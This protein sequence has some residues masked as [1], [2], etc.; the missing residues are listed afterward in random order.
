MNLKRLLSS[1]LGAMMLVPTAFAMDP[2]ER[3]ADSSSLT[4]EQQDEEVCKRWSKVLD[5]IE[6]NK[7]NLGKIS[8]IL[9]DLDKERKGMLDRGF[10]YEIT[11]NECYLRGCIFVCYTYFGLNRFLSHEISE[12]ELGSKYLERIEKRLLQ[13]LE[14]P[15]VMKKEFVNRVGDMIDSCYDV[16]SKK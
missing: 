12:E 3:R 4:F 15:H 9:V 10:E 11:W 1:L 13:L 8:R 16:F 14:K 5:E 2:P 6:E 7:N